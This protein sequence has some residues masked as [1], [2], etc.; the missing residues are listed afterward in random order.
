MGRLHWTGTGIA[1]AVS[2]IV[3]CAGCGSSGSSSSTGGT[4]GTP[5][6][7]AAG[8]LTLN[9]GVAPSTLD[10]ANVCGANDFLLATNL[11]TRLTQYGAKAG[12]GGTT[13]ADFAKVE[14]Y[15]AKSWK[16]S[17]GGK[18][19]RFTL[20]PDMK[21]P[22]GKPVDAAAVKYSFER[23]LK[24]NSCGGYFLE[25]GFVDPPVIK[26]IEAPDPQTLVVKLRHRDHDI[27]QAFAQSPASIVDPSVVEANGGVKAN[28]PNQWMQSHAAGAGPFLLKDYEPNQN[29]TLVRNPDYVGDPPA[30]SSIQVNFV[31]SDATLLLQAKTGDADVTL[32][33]SKQS[34]H[35]LEGASNVRV[36]PNDD[37][38]SE[39][40]GFRNSK[41]PFDNQTFRTALSYAVPYQQILDKVAFGYGKL[42]YGPLIPILPSFDAELEAPRPYDLEKARALVRQSGVKTPVKFEMVVQEGNAT[43]EQIA[44]IAQSTWR[45]LGVNVTVRKLSAS[46]YITGLQQ[47]KYDSYVRLAGAAIPT[48]SYFLG[49]D[50]KC[51]IS[52]NLSE[53][54][55]PKA[56]QLLERARAT[57][58]PAERKR[59]YDGITTLWQ[60]QAPEIPVYANKDVAVLSDRVEHYFYAPWPDMR[61]WAR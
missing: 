31:N 43:D 38:R 25:D 49:Y 46:D 17:D 2:V 35:S 59:F 50:M 41:A 56:D 13:T 23:T 39:F 16:I 44:T 36:I 47:H 40:I 4:G 42:Y 51:G 52:F 1:G 18:T 58:D 8:T 21:F 20:Q 53:T 27:L 32:N 34:V 57:D 7:G 3:A 22:S 14:P 9:A 48:A 33:L 55:I 45:Q 11:Y 15:A 19:Y 6:K 30:S 37:G 61:T 24:I 5:A 54:C 12:P 26:S 60:A 28:S 10:P 29:A